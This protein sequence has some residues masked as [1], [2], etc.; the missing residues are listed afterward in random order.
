MTEPPLKPT[1]FRARFQARAGL[2]FAE[3][4]KGL[5]SEARV[6]RYELE[7]LCLPSG[8]LGQLWS[9]S[10]FRPIEQTIAVLDDLQPIGNATGTTRHALED[11][12]LDIVFLSTCAVLLH[13]GMLGA[14]T[15][16]LYRHSLLFPRLHTQTALRLHALT[17]NWASYALDHA[18]EQSV[19]DL[20]QHYQQAKPSFTK[21]EQLS[22]QGGMWAPVAIAALAAI[23]ITKGEDLAQEL[24]PLFDESLR[25]FAVGQSILNLN[26]DLARSVSTDVIQRLAL[27][28][29]INPHDTAKQLD[30]NRIVLG[31]M[32]LPTLPELA[33]QAL[34]D[35]ATLVNRTSDAGFTKLGQSFYALAQPFTELLSLLEGKEP[36]NNAP[37]ICISPTPQRT[38][39]LRAASAYLDSDAALRE[40]WEEY[41]W[42]FIGTDLLTGRTFTTGLVLEQRLLAGDMQYRQLAAELIAHYETNDFHYFEQPST[43]PPDTDTLGLVLRLAAL[44]GVTLSAGFHAIVARVLENSDSSFPVFIFDAP[45]N[46]THLRTLT[47]Q[48]CA[49]V[50]AGFLAGYAQTGGNTAEIMRLAESLLQ[51]TASHWSA[52]F[53]HYDV[54]FGLV[55]LQTCYK[56]LQQRDIAPYILS[57]LQTTIYQLAAPFCNKV[58]HSPQD[59]A[60]LL[61]A[62]VLPQGLQAE[63]LSCI[64]RSQRPDGSWNAE[65]LFMA[66]NRGA[67]MT[68]FSSRTVTSSF[69]WHALT[70][71]KINVS[72]SP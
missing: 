17:G 62:N 42:G 48:T 5:H 45:D 66:P 18:W 52:A 32:L 51:C 50:H 3:V 60:Q 55:M 21:Q 59:A 68:P 35:V 58:K 54:P 11:A 36:Q 4:T 61:L 1:A 12:L 31:A 10:A 41:R 6:L 9:S 34:R 29:G 39:A 64:L 69:C 7:G 53:V 25:L 63:A 23:V 43:L 56:A 26:R 30:P 8:Q 27:D 38:Q 28:S 57:R 20:K 72:T 46:P 49:A 16:Y 14:E 22:L 15:G 13:D 71:S 67:R 40:A 2:L 70:V 33:R 47:G 44:S 37:S 24:M 65:P 19:A